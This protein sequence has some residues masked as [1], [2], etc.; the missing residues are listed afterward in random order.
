MQIESKPH[1][2]NV[3]SHLLQVPFYIYE[4]LLWFDTVKIHNNLTLQEWRQKRNPK[5]MDDYWFSKAALEHP[6]R[7]WDPSQARL[8]IVPTLLNELADQLAFHQKGI[9][10]GGTCDK[11]LVE[12]VEKSLA[13][14][15]W[16]QKNQGRDHIVVASHYAA[17]SVFRDATHLKNCNMIGFEA[18]KFNNPNRFTLP[19][20][21]VGT[22]CPLQHKTSDFAMVASLKNITTF[23][24]R[25]QICSWLKQT[26]YSVEAC[27]WGRQCPNLAR[28]RFGFHV[29]GDTFGSNRLF[30][31]ML[32]GTIPIF[33]LR[34]QYNILPSFVDWQSLS[35]FAD[36]RDRTEFLARLRSFVGGENLIEYTTKLKHLLDN[37][38]L[39]DWSTLVPFDVYMYVFAR[40][41]APDHQ[42]PVDASRYPAL[43]LDSV[44]ELA[45]SQQY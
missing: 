33:T 41:L 30:D 15:P 23:A 35:Y 7:T 5:H 10:V 22:R 45:S 38:D 40:V 13:E 3:Q 24:S 25:R 36:V 18:K 19:S 12:L 2:R 37:R 16:Y 17:H 6:M 42:I 28:A 27:G 21:Y 8:F 44:E 20:M 32:S 14:S 9:C 34:E 29:R 1:S 26:S 43:L 31:T 39:V 11:N 4:D